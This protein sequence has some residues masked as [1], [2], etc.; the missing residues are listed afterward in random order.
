MPFFCVFSF[1]RVGFDK[2]EFAHFLMFHQPALHPAL[3][4]FDLVVPA[5]LGDELVLDDALRVLFGLLVEF[6]E[7][8][9]GERAS[10]GCLSHY[11]YL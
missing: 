5:A 7:M 2:A 3:Q 10:I 9:Q 6:V 1:P 11:N 4:I 8:V